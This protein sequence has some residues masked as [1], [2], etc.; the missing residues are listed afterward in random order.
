MK[1]AN[2]F[3]QSAL[4]PEVLSLSS[5]EQMSSVLCEGIYS[6]F[7][8]TYGTKTAATSRVKKR[9]LHNRALKE[10]ERQKKDAWR[11]LRLARQ[12][13]SPA[14]V[15]QSLAT[16]FISLVR[17]HSKLKKAPDAR[18]LTREVK[19][20]RERCHRN[21]RQCAREILDGGLGQVEPSFGSE[22]ATAFF[23]E[24]YH[25][26]S[27][28]FVR[29][30]WM[31]TPSPP[32][33]EL[34]CSQ[35][36]E[37]E[38]ARVNKKMRAQSAPSHFDRVGY[39]IFKKCPSLLPAL[40]KLFNT[41][42]AQSTIPAEWKCAAIKLIPKSSSSEDPSNPD[43]FRPIALTPCVGKLFSTLLRNRWLRYMVNNKYLDSSLQKAF[44]P[45]VPGCTEHH[46]KLSSILS[47]AHSNHKSVAVCWLDLANAYGRVHHSL[48]DFSLH[49]Y[50]APPQF[51]STV[52]ALYTGLHA[53]VITAEW[54]TPVIPLQKGVYQGDP[55]SVVI[56]NTVINSLLDTV[57]LRSDLGYRFSN[58]RRQVNILQ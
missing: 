39:T 52:Q 17:S 5:P 24:V 33:V 18:L 16:H 11:K 46:Q 40:V 43:N 30:E 19:T 20:A 3:F 48:I 21:F 54:E 56:F 14:E 32:Q 22:A 27:R 29:P 4:V 41:C 53:K 58:S 49:H 50:H 1:I 51:L 31:P 42:W 9:P 6:Y 57:S 35:F 55:L 34:D 2:S 12:S 25:S 13:G 23:S 47:E 26:D 45:T 36:S 8:S 7:A 37:S 15:V 38:L 28:N 44:M 10:A